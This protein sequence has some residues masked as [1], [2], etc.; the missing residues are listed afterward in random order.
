[1]VEAER[2]LA[3]L[4]LPERVLELVAVA[5]RLDGRHDRLDRR[6]LEAPDALERVADLVLL[7]GE[8][9][10]VREHLP[11]SARVRRDRL[12]AIGRRLEQLHRVRLRE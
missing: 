2:E 8:L 12:D 11:G 1:V 3:A 10:L 7:L 4:V 5:Q 9:A 6:R